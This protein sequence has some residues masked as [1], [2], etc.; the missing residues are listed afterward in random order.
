MAQER[1]LQQKQLK[2]LRQ[3]RNVVTTGWLDANNTALDERCNKIF[4]P[5]IKSVRNLT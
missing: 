5:L 1:H 4:N 3:F 2:E